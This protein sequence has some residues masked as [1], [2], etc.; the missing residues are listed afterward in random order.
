MKAK[1]TEAKPNQRREWI[2]TQLR[3]Y[4]NDLWS[5]GEITC[6]TQGVLM[7]MILKVEKGAKKRRK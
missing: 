2:F 7:A 1:K 6:H 4:I 3:Q 5:S